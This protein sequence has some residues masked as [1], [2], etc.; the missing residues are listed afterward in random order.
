MDP[1]AL[2]E[3]TLRKARESCAVKEAFFREHAG[4]VTACAVAMA[5]AF[6][7]GGRLYAFGNGGSAC[8]AQHVAV[9]FMHPIVEKRKPL[10]AIALACD[11]ALL[12]AKGN[13]RDFSL[14]FVEQLS[15]QHLAVKR[16][17]HAEH[18][19]CVDFNLGELDVAG[20]DDRSL[21]LRAGI[22]DAC[23]G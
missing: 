13:D 5:E 7:R 17:L 9:E 2:R 11:P 16:V 6:E 12:T 21:V 15:V 14:S 10:P 3:A 22:G 4:R 18:I 19:R 23:N 8:D 1:A 20:H